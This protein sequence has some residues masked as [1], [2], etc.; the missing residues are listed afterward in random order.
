[1][2]FS[3]PYVNFHI[4]Y[5]NFQITCS[6]MRIADDEAFEDVHVELAIHTACLPQVLGKKLPALLPLKPVRI[7]EANVFSLPVLHKI[8]EGLED[9]WEL[10][11]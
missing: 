8:E 10:H 5:V 3:I 6:A 11:D 4:P 9:S 2:I 7:D 1:M